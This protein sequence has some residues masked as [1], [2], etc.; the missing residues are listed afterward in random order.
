MTSGPFPALSQPLRLACGRTLPNRLVGVPHFSGHAIAGRVS[1]AHL[2]HYAACAR[3]GLGLLVVGADAVNPAS[4]DP[5]RV[6]AFD[7]ACVEGYR[8][9]SAVVH[10]EGGPIV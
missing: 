2:A 3:G 7:P 5:T 10:A 1:E 8:V 9:L 4:P 6:A